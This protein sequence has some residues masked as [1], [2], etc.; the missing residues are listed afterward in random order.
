MQWYYLKDASSVSKVLWLNWFDN[1]NVVQWD[2]SLSFTHTCLIE[3]TK[4]TAL[5]ALHCTDD[6]DDDDD[7][8]SK[9][10]YDRSIKNNSDRFL[11]Y[12]IYIYTF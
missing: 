9:S 8:D 3:K 11:K 1:K 12:Q 5:Y 6:D 4:A 7:D 10:N 2:L